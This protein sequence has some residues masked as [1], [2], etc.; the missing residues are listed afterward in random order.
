[1]QTFDDL[2]IRG[3]SKLIFNYPGSTTVLDDDGS[4]FKIINKGVTQLA[5]DSSGVTIS[6]ATIDTVTIEN[7]DFS[8]SLEITDLNVSGSLVAE[9]IS[10]SGS[11]VAEDISVSGI[12]S[13]G[14]IIVVGADISQT[15]G[16]FTLTGGAGHGFDVL[17]ETIVLH[18]TS[19]ITLTGTCE[20]A[21]NFTTVGTV[22]VT[23]SQ[24]ISQKLSVDDGVTAGSYYIGSNAVLLSTTLG[25]NIVNSSLTSVGT[26]TDLTVASGVTLGGDVI[27]PTSGDANNVFVPPSLSD[28]QIASFG[29]TAP[30]GSVVYDSNATTLRIH[31]GTTFLTITAT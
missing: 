31:N 3:D 6:N 16:S 14:D 25:S 1:M 9:D 24:T 28:A 27:I 12:V 17:A 15:N 7:L 20:H 5:I 26:L 18:G 23:G 29:T 13:S 11:I 30:V 8:G 2:A 4:S 21:G 19:L 22:T 10:V